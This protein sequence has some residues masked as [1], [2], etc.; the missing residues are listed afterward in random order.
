MHMQKFT[1]VD[2]FSGAG[3]FSA[4]AMST[5]MTPVLAI[6]LAKEAIASYN[7]NV[8]PVGVVGSVLDLRDVPPADVLIAGPPCQGFST[9]G[10]QDPKDA[11]NKLALAVPVQIHHHLVSGMRETQQGAGKNLFV[12][13]CKVFA[14]SAVFDHHLA[15]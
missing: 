2:M 9:L 8:A 5:G 13:L 10:R 12:E 6:D 14:A 15:V 7:R 4:G 3:L 11:R 1:F